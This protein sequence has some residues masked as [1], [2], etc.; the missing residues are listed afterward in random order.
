MRKCSS[1][2]NFGHVVFCCCYY[3][4]CCCQLFVMIAVFCF[5]FSFSL[6]SPVSWIYKKF[7]FSLS[8]FLPISIYFS[9]LFPLLFY[10]T[11]VCN[12][13]H[14]FNFA[15]FFSFYRIT[16]LFWEFQ[17]FADGGY[18]SYLINACAQSLFISI[19]AMDCL[20]SF[21]LS[22]LTTMQKNEKE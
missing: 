12:M 16:V 2:A 7:L 21:S 15:I 5:L 8:L 20:F 22:V 10:T 4:R 3:W 11:F 9:F 18:E 6:G 17:C 13:Q 14:L 1:F 19:V